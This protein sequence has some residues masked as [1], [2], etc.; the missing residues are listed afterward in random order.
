[1]KKQLLIFLL[2]LVF[3]NSATAL[4]C[5]YKITENYGVEAF[6]FKEQ[7]KYLDYDV[8]EINNFQQSSRQG[9]RYITYSTSPAKFEIKNNYFKKIDAYIIF[10]MNGEEQIVEQTIDPKGFKTIEYPY[11]NNIDNSTFRFDIISPPNLQYVFENRT[12]QKNVCKYCGNEVCL[13]DGASCNPSYDDYKCGTGICTIAGFCGTKKIVDCPNGKLN[14]QD[15]LCLEPSTKEDGESY[16][17][18]FECKSDRYENGVCLKSS[19]FLQEEKDNRT[20][21][22][23]TYFVISISILFISLGFYLYL[24]NKNEKEK[25]RTIHEQ[26]A[27]IFTKLHAKNPELEK[28]KKE[29]QE[30]KIHKK[31][32]EDEIKNLKEFKEKE[33]ELLTEI[34]EIKNKISQ[35]HPDPQAKNQL[36]II[37]PHLGGYKCFY[38][39]ELELKEYPTSSL[40]HRWIWKNKTGRWP[41]QGYHI[42]HIDGNKYN[43]NPNN[44]EEIKGE[45]HFEMHRQSVKDKYFSANSHKH[46]RKKKQ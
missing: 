23:I 13:N 4:E 38:K 2:S 3:I 26:R 16:T 29:I 12:Y 31:H 25:Q 21:S 22:T 37:N 32:K 39:K 18:S 34:E 6:Y 15:K 30:I 40:L 43:N 28:I 44:L 46:L 35:P 11:P 7:N 33:S 10:I 1:M 41:R 27:L 17:C 45:E 14:C 5:Q 20:K 9:D 24:K 36:V 42:H 19:L 8:L